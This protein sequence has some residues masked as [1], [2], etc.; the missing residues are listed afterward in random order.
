[1]CSPDYYFV[2]SL[3]LLNLETVRLGNDILSMLPEC[4]VIKA[5]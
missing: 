4:A 3:W 1:M 2:D 5:I